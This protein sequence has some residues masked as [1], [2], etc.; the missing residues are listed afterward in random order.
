MNVIINQLVHQT[1]PQH[2]SVD[3][4]PHLPINPGAIRKQQNL[5]ANSQEDPLHRN[6]HP[7]VHLPVNP[8]VVRQR[9]NHQ[10][11]SQEDHLHR[12]VLKLPPQ[13]QIILHHR[14]PGLTQ[15]PT[16]VQGEVEVEAEGDK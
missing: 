4:Q 6:V 5:Q 8:G 15:A 12:L 9:Q 13:D 10:A 7:L 14:H 11:V 3:P 1:D 16:P 2:R